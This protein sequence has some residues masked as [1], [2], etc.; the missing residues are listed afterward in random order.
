M[1]PFQTFGEAFPRMA[2]I[3][4]N[5]LNCVDKQTFSSLQSVYDCMERFLPLSISSSNY[6]DKFVEYL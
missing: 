3:K 5:A 1:S 2:N 4:V 6:A